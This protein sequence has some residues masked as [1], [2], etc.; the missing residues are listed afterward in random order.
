MGTPERGREHT[1]RPR[2]P[3]AVRP[4]LET[5]REGLKEVLGENLVGIYIFGSVAFPDFVPRG[6]I[7]F[8]AIVHR[9]LRPTE[10]QRVRDLHHDLSQRFPHGDRLDGLYLPLHK[11]QGTEHPRGRLGLRPRDIVDNEWPLHREHIHRGAFVVLCGQ[12]PRDFMP[13]VSLPELSAALKSSLAYIK[14][15]LHK[16]PF[17][18]VLN[19]CRL[20]CTWETREVALS[21]VQG[22][23]W[24][25]A[26]L[27]SRW[28]PL[29]R[30]ALRVYREQERAG[31]QHLLAAGTDDFFSYAT[32]R[33]ASAKRQA[34]S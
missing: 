7:D 16:H 13:P 32:N 8:Y 11:A 14:G 1:T 24:A 5:F 2:L 33:I 10:W 20:V 19:L 27:P 25:L 29:I 9:E 15:L 28:R 23:H 3:A 26:N 4:L 17:W 31:D 6:D 22:A 30:S 12:D 21:K 34:Q 18:C